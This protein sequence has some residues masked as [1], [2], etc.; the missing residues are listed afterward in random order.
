MQQ[1]QLISMILHRMRKTRSKAAENISSVLNVKTSIL[2][3]WS[4]L[5]VAVSLSPGCTSQS[6]RQMEP[7][8]IEIGEFEA[9]PAVWGKR[10]PDH[11]DSYLKNNQISRTEYGGS[12]KYSKLEREPLLKILFNGYSFSKEYNEDRGHTYALEDIRMIDPARKSAGTCITCKTANF[13]E[14]YQKYGETYYTQ[15]ITQLLEESKHPTN[16]IDCH[17]PK[18]NELVI[19]RPALKEAF[20]RQGRD[21]TKAS[22]AEMRSLVC[23]QCHVEYYFAPG[24]KKLVFPWDKGV[25]ADQIYSYYEEINFSDWTHPDSKTPLLKAQHPDW[26]LFQG[27]THQENNVS[28]ADCHMP[29]VR[30]GSSKISSHWWTSPLKQISDSCGTCHRQSEDY[31]KDRILYTQ[32]RV[33]DQMKKAEQAVAGAIASIGE[34]SK[35]PAANVAKLDEARKLHRQAQWYVD[36]IS[37]ENSMGFHNPQEALRLLS[38]SQRLAGESRVRALESVSAVSLPPL[39]NPEPQMITTEEDKSPKK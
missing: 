33:Y 29:Y 23:A 22:R 24:T 5:F 31:L 6:K 16:C 1:K 12:D 10:Y 19:T 36:Y 27:S 14:L 34:T 39:P 18:T 26:Q 4:A 37:S 30:V 35:N 13:K 15:P 28:C 3:V 32:R 25:K 8:N 21:I 11:Y 2:L 17:D 20:E 38:E 9:D 7:Q